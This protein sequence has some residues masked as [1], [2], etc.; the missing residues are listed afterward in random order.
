MINVRISRF[1]LDTQR[2][3]NASEKLHMGAIKLASALSSP[4]EVGRTVIIE[5]RGGIL[6]SKCLL[7]G[8]KKT[9]M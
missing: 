9:L 8:K 5:A 3:R 6:T 1:Y 7:I 4:Q 2:V